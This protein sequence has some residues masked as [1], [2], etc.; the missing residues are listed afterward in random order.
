LKTKTASLDRKKSAR[1]NE[2]RRD[3]LASY[4]PRFDTPAL[5]AKKKDFLEELFA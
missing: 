2:K 5:E 4:H 1:L 3:L